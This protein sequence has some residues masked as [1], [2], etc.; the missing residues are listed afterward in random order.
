MSLT[1]K[2]VTWQRQPEI[3]GGVTASIQLLLIAK[4]YLLIERR[5]RGIDRAILASQGSLT[6][7]T[8]E[9]TLENQ[10]S[11]PVA[12]KVFLSCIT[13][14]TNCQ[15]T[16]TRLSV[17]L[18]P[19][20]CEA[21]GEMDTFGT[22]EWVREMKKRWRL[23]HTDYTPTYFGCPAMT[24]KFLKNIMYYIKLKAQL[25]VTS[26]EFLGEEVQEHQTKHH[27]SK[28]TTTLA[29]FGAGI[30]FVRS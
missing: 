29:N 1:W 13:Y 6:I 5:A 15:D 22:Q 18:V 30:A 12:L 24:G 14:V 23:R 20:I 11:N 26:F 17:L 7:N 16:I 19:Q 27:K 21:S 4:N 2:F 10:D 8:S 9:M 28:A 25:Q 3:S